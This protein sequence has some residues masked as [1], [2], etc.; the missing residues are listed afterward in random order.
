L[1]HLCVVSPQK[2]RETTEWHEPASPQNHQAEKYYKNKYPDGDSM[3]HSN[4]A[5]PLGALK[6]YA[7]GAAFNSPEHAAIIAS[8]K[9]RS[10]DY[11]LNA[12]DVP[13][14][15][16][17]RQGAL[18]QLRENNH[19]LFQHAVPVMET[20]YAQI[21]NT[22]SMV[23][24]TARSGT[25][26]HSLGDLDFLEKAAQVALAPGAEWS[27][28]CKGTNAIGTALT[29]G[30]RCAWRSALLESQPVFNVL[31]HTHL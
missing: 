30:Q 23:I 20:L 1:E 2:V 14:F 3:L 29:E 25:I 16:P 26:L 17:L 24:L 12:V 19:F 31:V 6:Q 8:S 13:D 5:L 11:G 22:H 27:E 18:G 4:A 21:A 15:T 7:Q 9:E 10:R 28:R